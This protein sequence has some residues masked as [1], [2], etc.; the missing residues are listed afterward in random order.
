MLGIVFDPMYFVFIGPAVLLGIW[1]QAKVKSAFAHASRVRATTGLSGAE[2][3]QRILRSYGLANV[4]IEPT[5]GYLGDHYDPK[6]KVLRLSPDVYAGRSVAALGIAA[7]EAG[8]AIQDA[9]SYGPLAL[10]GGILPMASIG[11]NL[12]FAFVL[13]GIFLGMTGLIW[14][15]IA[16]FSAVVLFQLVNLPVEYNASARALQMLRADGLIVQQEE[17]EVRRVLNAAAWTYVAATLTAIATL[18]YYL[19][20]ARGRN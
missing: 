4:R 10:R 13:G 19:T 7:H 1:A 14:V 16:L 3:A 8:H 5:H 12:S 15:G 18:A 20:I 9:T 17:P 6:A 2:A 11:S